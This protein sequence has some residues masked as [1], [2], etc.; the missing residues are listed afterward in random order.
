MNKKFEYLLYCLIIE[1]CTFSCNNKNNKFSNLDDIPE[2]DL[3]SSIISKID[4]EIISMPG[5]LSLL[6][7]KIFITSEAG[8]GNAITEYDIYGD[9]ICSGLKYGQGPNEILEITGFHIIND[10]IYLYDARKGIINKLN[11]GN[12]LSLEPLFNNITLKDDAVI[13][14]PNILVAN[15]AS[16]NSYYLVNKKGIVLDSLSY[17]P[18]IPNGIDKFTHSLACTGQLSISKSGNKFIRTIAYDGGIDIFGIYNDKLKHI[19]RYE[20]FPMEYS[21]MEL[22]NGHSVPVPNE[23]S[24][25]GFVHTAVSNNYFYAS[26]SDEKAKD[27]PYGASKQVYKFDLEGGIVTI[28]NLDKPVTA[29]AVSPDDSKI[30]ALALDMNS[31]EYEIVSF[32]LTE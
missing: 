7:N 15:T 13:V 23:N 31:D 12:G 26:F 16:P 30:Y 25:S 19:N 10:S 22:P 20:I 28:Y 9:N 6:G 1:L 4:P 11:I 5:N 21:V 8:T 32:H 18:P 27:N 2:Y 24:K 17:F 3:S 14:A 29:F